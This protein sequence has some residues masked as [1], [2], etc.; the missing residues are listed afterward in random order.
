MLKLLL[1]FNF[2]DVVLHSFKCDIFNCVS[3]RH[4]H[5]NKSYRRALN[6]EPAGSLRTRRSW[7]SRRANLSHWPLRSLC[8]TQWINHWNMLNHLIC[9]KENHFIKFIKMFLIIVNIYNFIN[10]LKYI[11][12]QCIYDSYSYCILFYFIY[13]LFVYYITT[14][15]L[16]MDPS[17]RLN[18]MSAKLNYQL[19]SPSSLYAWVLL[20]SLA[21]FIMRS[22]RGNRF[23]QLS[24]HL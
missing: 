12:Y 15:C 4:T 16:I 8:K 1:D 2:L 20:L 19:W 7:G 22:T 11:K 17:H 9:A 5:S 14:L 3:S 24:I 21:A 13:L 18:I 10:K 6:R 23:G